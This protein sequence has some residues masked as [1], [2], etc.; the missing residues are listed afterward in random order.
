MN[1]LGA[2]PGKTLRLP[3][4]FGSVSATVSSE[5]TLRDFVSKYVT[6][7]RDE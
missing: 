3:T 2:K 1:V 6:G 7:R 4:V 5:L